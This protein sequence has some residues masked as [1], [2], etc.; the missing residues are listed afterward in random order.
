MALRST[1]ALFQQGR[2]LLDEGRP[3]DAVEPLEL[4]ADAEPDAPSIHEA[5]GRAYFAARRHAA[6]REAF[7]AAVERDPTDAYAHFGLGRA[8]ERTGQVPEAL[9]HLRLAC[10]LEPRA[11]FRRRL[12][13]VE[14]RHGRD[15]GGPSGG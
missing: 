2:R 14:A 11:D 1:Y 6:A 3:V 10:A 4:A 12:S 15:V 13:A 9:R 5:L 8:L 7:A